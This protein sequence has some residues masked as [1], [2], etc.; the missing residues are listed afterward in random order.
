MP[1]SFLFIRT[2]CS[3]KR[4]SGWDLFHLLPALIYLLDHFVPFLPATLSPAWIIALQ[5]VIYIAF[6]AEI[7]VHSYT[8]LLQKERPPLSWMLQFI[9]L[10][11]AIP[12]SVL[13][14]PVLPIAGAFLSI[15]ALYF[16]PSI[17][18]D[19]RVRQAH[20]GGKPKFMLDLDFAE[21]LSLRLENIM[22]EKKPYLNPDYSLRDLADTLDVPLYKLS[23]YLNQNM[24][25][26]FSEYLNQWRIRHCLELLR[27]KETLQLNL[28]GI[29]RK[30]GFNNRNTFSTAFKKITGKPPSAYLH[31]NN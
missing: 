7:L 10:Q 8:G 14:T 12:L 30:C 2:V 5:S 6:Q 1:L 18:Y 4:Y 25:T 20:H 31:A 22:Q 9:V 13:T 23:A 17:L 11:V 28:N 19:E 16:H 29:A 26:N 3:A 15:T 27:N 24:G 21:H